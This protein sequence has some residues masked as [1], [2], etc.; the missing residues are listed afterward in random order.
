MKG[1]TCNGQQVQAQKKRNYKSYEKKNKETNDLIEKKIQQ[2]YQ[3]QEKKE[4]SKRNLTFPG[5]AD[6]DDESKKSVI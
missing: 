4:D 3:E 1:I 6:A 5:N 2:T